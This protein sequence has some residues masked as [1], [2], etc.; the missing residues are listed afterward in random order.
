MQSGNELEQT[1]HETIPYIRT[2]LSEP[3]ILM[4]RA[5]HHQGRLRHH[6]RPRHLLPRRQHSSTWRSYRRHKRSFHMLWASAPK[7]RHPI[8]LMETRGDDAHYHDGNGKKVVLLIWE[9][10][11][12]LRCPPP[13][14]STKR[15]I[16][17]LS[18]PDKT[19]T[20]K[21]KTA[22]TKTFYCKSKNNH[23]LC[24]HFWHQ[25]YCKSKANTDRFGSSVG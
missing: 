23:Y 8:S 2:Y 18:K 13:L 7:R 24:S 4:W 19:T 3:G 20:L 21:I 9:K 11:G 16:S 12:L 5:R 22:R 15:S 25:F 10:W 6:H 1:A 14:E 17:V